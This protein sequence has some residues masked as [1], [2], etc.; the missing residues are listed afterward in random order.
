MIIEGMT[1]NFIGP[2]KENAAALAN[3]S[4]VRDHFPKKQEHFMIQLLDLGNSDE[5]DGCQ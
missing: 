3:S 4:G 1:T 5:E 2:P